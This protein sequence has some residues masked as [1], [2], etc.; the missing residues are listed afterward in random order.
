MTNSR[1]I[2]QQPRHL[3]PQPPTS[4][5]SD[6]DAGNVKADALERQALA[7]VDAAAQRV[8]AAARDAFPERNDPMVV[9]TEAVIAT[10]AANARASILMNKASAARLRDILD[11][12]AAAGG[13]APERTFSSGRMIDA[14]R[15]VGDGSSY[16][17]DGDAR[18]QHRGRV[19]R[20]AI[21]RAVAVVLLIGVGVVGEHWRAGGK[22]ENKLS[23]RVAGLS[24]GEQA[25]IDRVIDAIQAG[26]S[27]NTHALEI[28]VPM[29][30]VDRVLALKYSQLGTSE[31]RRAF[32]K[33][34]ELAARNSG[35]PKFASRYP[36]CIVAGPSGLSRESITMRTCLVEIPSSV[37]ET[38]TALREYYQKQ[39]PRALR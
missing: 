20:G 19:G 24:H 17:L 7:G 29:P 31:F 11:R 2:V 6:P 3:P 39:A 10:S 18:H 34:A 12:E 30:E 22:P 23:Q 38:D 26:Q 9:F 15:S 1:G 25:W 21:L 8:H 13:R 5:P 27:D 36:G 32:I 33:T 14:G 28:L 37:V 35:D 16:M 4:A